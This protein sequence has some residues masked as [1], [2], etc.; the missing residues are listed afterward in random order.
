MLSGSTNEEYSPRYLQSGPVVLFQCA[1]RDH[2]RVCLQIR[3][4]GRRF[5]TGGL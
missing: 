2:A 1:N 4:F 3:V 5:F